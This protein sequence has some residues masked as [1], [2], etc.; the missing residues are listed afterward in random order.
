MSDR[1]SV[2]PHSRNRLPSI[3]IPSRGAVSGI[4]RTT[5]MVTAMGK[6]IFSALET[7]RSWVILTWRISL[8]VRAFISGGWIMGIRAM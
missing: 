3:S 5:K 7:V 1:R 8:V 2:T 6:M 4:S